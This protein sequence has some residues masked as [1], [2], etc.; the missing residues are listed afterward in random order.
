MTTA[1]VCKWC[2]EMAVR[3]QG[4]IWL[5]KRHYRFQQMRVHAKRRGKTAP[6][7]EELERLGDML[8]TQL[9]CQVCYRQ[10]NWLGAEGQDTVISLRHDAAGGHKL[11][12]RSC[13]TRATAMPGDSFYDLPPGMKMCHSCAEIKSL[14][15][16]TVDRTRHLLRGAYC[17]ECSG[18]RVT[19]WVKRRREQSIENRLRELVRNRRTCSRIARQGRPARIFTITQED[20]FY[21]Y[22]EQ[23][24]LCYYSGVHLEY[25]GT[26]KDR[27]VSLDRKDSSLGYELNNIALCCWRVNNMKRELNEAMF[28]AW[29]GRISGNHRIEIA[30]QTRA[31]EARGRRW[32]SLES[33][34][35]VKLQNARQRAR[36][37]GKVASLT[38][39]ELLAT[40]E[41]QEGRCFYSKQPL[42][43]NQG[44]E[45]DFSIDRLDN[46]KGY[47]SENSVLCC[48]RVN[49]MKGNLDSS[50]FFEWVE[51]IHSR[52]GV[53]T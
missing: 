48:W 13:S 8:G 30:P 23:K 31:L 19:D 14:N 44:S 34:M 15:E 46:S 50:S 3:R 45:L 5:C 51:R 26:N 42:T 16:F 11:I 27:L 41:T 35:R 40:Y 53:L 9:H 36:R 52:R 39:D 21:M 47:T 6:S 25:D 18:R 28:L 22:K 32:R 49:N 38:L 24:G 4:R 10:M 17:R 12:C 7:Y 43:F 20:V 1:T 37:T 29:C 2:N 33:A